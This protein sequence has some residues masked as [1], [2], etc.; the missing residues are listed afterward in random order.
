M[1]PKDPKARCS[2][3]SKRSAD[4][5]GA[6]RVR[7]EQAAHAIAKSVE[8]AKTTSGV[9]GFRKRHRPQR[10]RVKQKR[11]TGK[12]LKNFRRPY[13]QQATP[14][15]RFIR[16]SAYNGPLVFPACSRQRTFRHRRCLLSWS[17]HGLANAAFGRGQRNALFQ[18]ERS[19]GRSIPA[20]SIRNP[21]RHSHTTWTRSSPKSS[22]SPGIGSPIS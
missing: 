12:Y 19:R 22:I 6:K 11:Q 14:E 2:M 8:L 5:L 17:C 16:C 13:R 15:A 4:S 10:R 20:T 3:G 9:C 18:Q 21:H 1:S 7:Q